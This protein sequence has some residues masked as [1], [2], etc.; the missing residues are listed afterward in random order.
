MFNIITDAIPL[1]YQEHIKSLMTELSWYWHSNTSY[2]EN[3]I[4]FQEI[5]RLQQRYPNIID[6]GQ[7]THAILDNG[8]TFSPDVGLLVPILYMFADKAGIVVNNIL[9][10][11]INLMVQDKTF[12][13]ENF[14]CPHTDMIPSKVFLYYVNDC[15]GDT[16][17]FDETIVSDDDP[18]PT[19]FNII[20]RISP[21]AGKG[22]FFDGSR[23]H[24][25]S[26]PSTYKV[27]YVINFN[28]T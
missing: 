10:I 27:R 5:Q 28:F 3:S 13:Y 26:S 14:N 24:A 19:E 16:I 22:V 20:K 4:R 9:R 17:L 7:F 6:N 15:D 1:Q 21:K 8:Q 12:T 18:F 2:S 11:R 23:F 25:S